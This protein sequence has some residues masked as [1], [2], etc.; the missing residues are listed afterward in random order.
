MAAVSTGR[1]HLDRANS[2]DPNGVGQSSLTGRDG[3]GYPRPADR[4]SPARAGCNLLD[5]TAGTVWLPALSAFC[6]PFVS[7]E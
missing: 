7:P 2:M 6:Q 1:A 4:V 5:A 3:A